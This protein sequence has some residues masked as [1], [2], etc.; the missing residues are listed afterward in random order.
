MTD[1]RHKNHRKRFRKRMQQK[2]EK[3]TMANATNDYV[4]MLG[5]T[6]ILDHGVS[7][8]LEAYTSSIQQQLLQC[9]K[10]GGGVIRFKCN[11]G[12]ETQ[13]LYVGAASSTFVL[14]VMTKADFE[15]AQVAVAQQQ[16][17]AKLKALVGQQQ[18]KS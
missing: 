14:K 2:K 5:N 9:Q 16:E 8:D 1:P 12:R 17:L 7:D 10:D 4:L 6:V 18:G 3:T 15:A 11:N 13:Y